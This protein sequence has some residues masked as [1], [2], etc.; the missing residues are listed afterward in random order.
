MGERREIEVYKGQ[1]GEE[2]A[3][4][5]GRREGAKGEEKERRIEI[6]GTPSS[7]LLRF[8]A[9]LLLLILGCTSSDCT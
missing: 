5:K 9:I 3:L 7:A 4:C 6:A 2:D 1:E 8:S